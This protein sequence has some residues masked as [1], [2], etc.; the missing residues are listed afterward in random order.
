MRRTIVNCGPRRCLAVFALCAGAAFL[1]APIGAETEARDDVIPRL[2]GQPNGGCNISVVG[3]EFGNYDIHNPQPL[4]SFSTLT[5]NCSP[6]PGEGSVRNVRIQI[7]RGSSPTFFPRTMV[8]PGG[9]LNYNLFLDATRQTVWGDDSGGTDD[10][11]LDRP[12]PNQDTTVPI[13]G[14]V[15][16]LQPVSGGRYMDLLT[17]TIL[18]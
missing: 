3:L 17:V 7:S 15:E 9:N 11:F 18:F 12:Q 8:G 10:Y 4:D 1:A 13:Y 14:R 6:I 2:Q 16:P 5:F